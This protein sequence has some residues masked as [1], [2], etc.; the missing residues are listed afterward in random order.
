MSAASIERLIFGDTPALAWDPTARIP[1]MVWYSG[2][3]LLVFMGLVRVLGMLPSMF[4]L[5]VALGYL[6][7]ERRHWVLWL[8]AVLL[9]AAI[10]AVFARG[11][12]VPMPK[13]LF[14]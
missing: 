2:A 10:W 7:G 12:G 9:T 1:R 4:V 8:S 11:F 14:A 13:G 5:L 3:A 6:W